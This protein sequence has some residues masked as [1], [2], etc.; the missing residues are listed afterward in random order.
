MSV[1]HVNNLHI[2][3]GGSPVKYKSSTDSGTLSDDKDYYD[4]M[5]LSDM[6]SGVLEPTRRSKQ[7][8]QQQHYE[9][10]EEGQIVDITPGHAHASASED[11]CS[12]HSDDI[13]GGSDISDV[14]KQQRESQSKQNFVVPP[15]I[16]DDESTVDMRP[17]APVNQ[18]VSSYVEALNRQ[19]TRKNRIIKLGLC[20]VSLGLIAG[21][22]F[23]IVSV[24]S[25]KN[26]S[27]M[28]G[29]DG[30]DGGRSGLESNHLNAK[31]GFSGNV[32]T[33]SPSLSPV[34]FLPEGAP[35]PPMGVLDPSVSP[36]YVPGTTWSTS[37]SPT[38]HPH[39]AT[40]APVASPVTLEPTTEVCKVLL[41]VF[42]STYAHSLQ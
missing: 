32:T 39:G 16:N 5:D 18:S 22:A 29:M 35:A 28:S 1:I 42:Y 41:K 25:N 19:Q 2:V 10:E 37:K 20:F 34:D 12:L 27:E 9:G 4:G 7:E 3:D 33:G 40:D 17:P 13:Y 11:E 38:L 30:D 31:E 14:E 26:E 15:L 24:T 21:V 8:K 23:G 36:T 6:I